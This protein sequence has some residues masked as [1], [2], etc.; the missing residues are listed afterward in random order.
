MLQA[1][2]EARRRVLGGL[3]QG[4]HLRWLDGQGPGREEAEAGVRWGRGS[5]LGGRARSGKGEA[6]LCR[7]PRLCDWTAGRIPLVLEWER[8][9]DSLVVPFP[10]RGTC[11]GFAQLRQPRA[12]RATEQECCRG[13]PTPCR[14]GV[15][16]TPSGSNRLCSAA[17]AAGRHSC[18]LRSSFLSAVVS[19]AGSMPQAPAEGAWPFSSERCSQKSGCQVA[20]DRIRTAAGPPPGGAGF[21]GSRQVG[22]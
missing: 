12:L 10:Q 4:V 17:T 15:V 16:R 13:P 2:D 20:N 7:W 18:R 14:T 21:R 9:K 5:L 22:M 8:H 1:R 11:P 3:R 19:T 6:P